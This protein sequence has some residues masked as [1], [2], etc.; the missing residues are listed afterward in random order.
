MPATIAS[1]AASTAT[2]VPIEFP[3]RNAFIQT[4]AP[5]VVSLAATA[6]VAPLPLVVRAQLPTVTGPSR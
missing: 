2:L 6:F 4:Q 1:P 5:A 3:P